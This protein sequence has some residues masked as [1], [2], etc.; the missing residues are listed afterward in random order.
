MFV[1]KYHIRGLGKLKSNL[2]VCGIGCV[3]ETIKEFRFINFE[4][5]NTLQEIA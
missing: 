4:T 3:K 5:V 1:I 2:A